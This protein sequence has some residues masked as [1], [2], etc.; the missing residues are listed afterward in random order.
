MFFSCLGHSLSLSFH[1]SP[2]LSFSSSPWSALLLC[3]LPTSPGPWLILLFLICGVFFGSLCLQR[4]TG[5]LKVSEPSGKPSLCRS[6][7]CDAGG[8]AGGPAGPPQPGICSPFSLPWQGVRCQGRRGWLP[9]LALR[10]FGAGNKCWLNSLGFQVGVQVPSALC[11]PAQGDPQ[12]WRLQ[13]SPG[14]SHSG[15]QDSSEP[16]A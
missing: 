7:P 9:C 11:H 2:H 10:M 8:L 4:G 12:E 16:G 1:L 3:L 14:H 6:Q 15:F 13:A 5:Q